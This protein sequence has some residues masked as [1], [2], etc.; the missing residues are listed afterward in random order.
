MIK[1][2]YKSDKNLNHKQKEK[3]TYFIDRGIKF[4]RTG[5]ARQY[6]K[7][8]SKIDRQALITN[9]NQYEMYIDIFKKIQKLSN[10]VDIDPGIYKDNKVELNRCLSYVMLHIRGKLRC[11][12]VKSIEKMKKHQ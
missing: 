10:E 9:V 3:L 4:C 2:N 6:E 11:N 8:H 1:Q 5:K 7:I 12:N